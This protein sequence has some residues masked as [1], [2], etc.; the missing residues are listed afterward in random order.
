VNLLIIK[1]GL[2]NLIRVELGQIFYL[3][4]KLM[5]SIKQ[6]NL[7]RIKFFRNPFHYGGICVSGTIRIPEREVN[8]LKRMLIDQNGFQ[9]MR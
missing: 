6:L 1:P 8:A 7:F 5:S 3:K 2:L 9:N 4:S